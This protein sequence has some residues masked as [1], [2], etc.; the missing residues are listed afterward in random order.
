VAVC[1][2]RAFLAYEDFQVKSDRPAAGERGLD[3]NCVQHAT[4]YI[5]EQCKFPPSLQAAHER[6]MWSPL[7]MR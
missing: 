2:K 6:H 7:F 1:G 4:S 5:V 3:K